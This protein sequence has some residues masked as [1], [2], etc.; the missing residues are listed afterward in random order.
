MRSSR[1]IHFFLLLAIPAAC[2]S[3][4][5]KIVS[6]TDGDTINVIL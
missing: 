1:L 5:A 2:F 6:I 3:W 4:S